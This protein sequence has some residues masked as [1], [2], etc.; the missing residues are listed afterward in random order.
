MVGM[1][2][3]HYDAFLTGKAA[4]PSGYWGKAWPGPCGSPNGG[5]TGQDWEG[6]SGPCW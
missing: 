2:L 1:A 5:P 4:W 6:A 3:H